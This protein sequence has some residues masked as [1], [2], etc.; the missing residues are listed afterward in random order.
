MMRLNIKIKVFDVKIMVGFVFKIDSNNRDIKIN[1]IK[2][3]LQFNM[4]G[5]K[6]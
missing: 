2:I 6:I 3:L 5:F 1:L 4:V